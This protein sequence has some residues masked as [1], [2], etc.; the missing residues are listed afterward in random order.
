VFTPR[1]LDNLA[2]TVDYFNIEVEGAIT[3]GFLQSDLDFCY[4]QSNF[5]TLAATAGNR[6]FGLNQRAVG[7]NLIN[8]IDIV[9]NAQQLAT[10]GID[11]SVTYA[12]DTLA[13]IPG[14]L[15]V[16][17]RGSYLEN[18]EQDGAE[19]TGQIFPANGFSLPEWRNVL[20]LD[21]RVNEQ[22]S[23]R[24]SANYIGSMD[25]PA[26]SPTSNFR[27]YDGPE[28]HTTYDFLARF[29]P[30]DL[31]TLRFGINNVGD[32][33]APYAFNTGNNTSPSTYDV[34]GRYFF[35]AATTR[36]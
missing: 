17:L 23:F 5:A 20:D 26:Q 32:D 7:G 36:F 6:C 15:G 8:L 27:K 16:S 9:R 30:T 11:Y 10:S 28:A 3:D 21:Y 13:F 34:L 22:F 25:D 29:N 24:L 2:V 14:S 18:Y 4:A 31:L 33:D 35:V 1:F 19:L 12:F